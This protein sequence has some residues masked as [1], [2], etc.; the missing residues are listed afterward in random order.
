MRGSARRRGLAVASVL[1]AGLAVWAV[2]PGVSAAADT[3]AADTKAADTKPAAPRDFSVE[4]TFNGAP[5]RYRMELTSTRRGYRIYRLTYPSP[6][7]TP[8]K[9]NNTVPADYYLP[10]GIEPGSAKRPAVVC[11]HILNGNYELVRMLCSALASRGIPAVMFKLPYYGERSLPGGRGE[12]ARKPKLFVEAL[13]QGIQDARR[14]VDVLASRPEVD[15]QRIGISGISLGGIVAGTTA[16]A[17]P[18]INRAVLILAGGDLLG[19][20]HHSR[21]ARDLSEFIKKLPAEDRA[22]I[23]KAIEEVDPLRHAAGLKDRAAA[24][25]VLMVNASEDN[26][27]PR[28]CTEK[29]AAALGISE[30]VVWL[31]GLGHYTA[32]L[33]LPQTLRRTVDFFAL[34]MPPGVTGPAQA[35]AASRAPLQVVAGLVTQAASVLTVEPAKG[36]YHLVALEATVTDKAGKTYYGRVRFMR[37]PGHRFSLRLEAP[38]IGKASLGQGDYPWIASAKTVFRGVNGEVGAAQDPLAYADPKYT[39]KVRMLAGGVAAVSLAPSILEQAVRVE[40]DTQ[41]DGPPAIRITPKGK[42]RDSV[43]LVLDRERKTPQTV[44][45]DVDGVKGKITFVGWQTNAVAQQQALFEP[46]ADLARKD[47][48]RADIHRIFSAMFNFVMELTE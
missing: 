41:G 4:K 40:D 27:V 8:V 38:I 25:K 33:A 28:A 12:L 32:I 43:R 30:R 31:R 2:M 14:T 1:L 48:D 24:G 23:E 18:R 15:P 34:D 16:G 36:R 44:T 11:I 35:A 46:P 26:V 17:D 6:V 19:V 47:V 20:V 9:Q 29:L 7:T 22:K 37:G 21:E 3:K 42:K 45:F 13:P 10:D 39:A 5:F